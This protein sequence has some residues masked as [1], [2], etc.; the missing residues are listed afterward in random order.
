M[1]NLFTNFGFRL[2]KYKFTRRFTKLLFG[3]SNQTLN[4]EVAGIRF[5]NPIGLSAGFDYEGKLTNTLPNISF[6]FESTGTVTNHLYEGN[7]K[8]RLVRLKKSKS[9]LVNKGFKS[10]GIRHFLEEITFEEKSFN[11]GISIGATNSEAT[12]TPETQI[13][14]IV[15]S[16]KYLN[17]H[18]KAKR[19]AYY[20][21]NISCPNVLGSGSLATPIYLEQVLSELDK[22]HLKKPLFIKFPL[23]IEWEKAKE[24]IQIMIEHKV[25]AVIVANLLKNRESNKISD[26]DKEKIKDLKGNFSGKPTYDLSNELIAKIYKEF[27]NQIKIV[28]VG[29]VFNA[30][31]AY[32]KIKNG[33]SLV[34]LITGMVYNG[35]QL[36]KQIN[37]G[38]A[39]KLKQD[40]LQNISQAVG[41]YYRN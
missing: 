33:A 22:I 25:S 1:H 18:K 10:S 8:P 23:E 14:D 37:K 2:G 26:E 34:Q 5:L 21:L 15:Q 19:F 20:E 36:I 38:L 28:G 6:G 9:L 13:Q 27:G 24:L 41:L 7:K 31:D 3:Y 29:G 16:F 11:V 17:N 40:N 4:T 30:N 39:K 32:E 12:S 35:P